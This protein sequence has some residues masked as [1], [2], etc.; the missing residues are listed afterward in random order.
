MNESMRE[1]TFLILSALADQPRHGYGIMAEASA[2]SDGAVQLQAG[3]LYAALDRLTGEGLIAVDREEV[4][5][6]RHRRYLALT[7]A[8]REALKAE[9]ERR[10]R[11]A[12]RALSRLA[13]ATTPV[14]SS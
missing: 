9:A 5:D 11:V 8:G 3:T 12:E 1:P 6:G 10:R 13:G 7:D 14:V 4:V 2:L